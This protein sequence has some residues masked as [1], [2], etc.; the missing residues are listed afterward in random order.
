[1]SQ[2]KLAAA[3]VLINQERYEE[4]R[5]VLISIDD[6]RVPQWLHELDRRETSRRRRQRTRVLRTTLLLLFITVVGAAAVIV[7]R[8]SQADTTGTALRQTAH[9]AFVRSCDFD[10][11]FI[12]DQASASCRD[13][14]STYVAT[15]SVQQLSD[16]LTQLPTIFSN[17]QTFA[18]DPLGVFATSTAIAVR[19]APGSLATLLPGTI[20]ADGYVPPADDP[21]G[22]DTHGGVLT[23]FDRNG[24]LPL[25]PNAP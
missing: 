5:Q 24:S 21:T 22:C 6:P 19:T 8:A 4:A 10:M 13:D 25:P 20:C 11:P 17:L 2:G 3:R 23:E 12:E 16:E 1:M 7:T 15:S 18:F 14:L 9:A